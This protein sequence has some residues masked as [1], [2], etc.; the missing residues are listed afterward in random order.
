MWMIQLE[1]IL[2]R[3]WYGLVHEVWKGDV[4]MLG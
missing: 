3:W 2:E 1:E 4:G